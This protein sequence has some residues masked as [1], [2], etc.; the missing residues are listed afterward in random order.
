MDKLSKELPQ[1]LARFKY[2]LIVLG[3]GV[4]LMLLPSRSPAP[5]VSTQSQ[6]VAQALENVEGVG[7]AQVLISDKGVVVV[8]S[9][10]EDAEVKM[11][12]LRAVKAYTGFTSD[13]ISILK[14]SKYSKGE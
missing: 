10:A 2:P 7:R 14:M 6:L 12:I 11:D 5:E 8:C 9:G 1:I 4:L 13:K 3:L